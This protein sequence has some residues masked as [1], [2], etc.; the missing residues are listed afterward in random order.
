MPVQYAQPE[1]SH[2]DRRRH[3]SILDVRYFRGADC[4]TDCCLVV[5]EVRERET[6]SEQASC[7]QVKYEGANVY[8]MQNTV[9]R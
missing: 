7:T 1:L 2:F 8:W 9:L 6:G 3:S 4:D 5:A